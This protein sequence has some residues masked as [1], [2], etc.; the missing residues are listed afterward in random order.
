MRMQTCRRFREKEERGLSSMPSGSFGL[1][2]IEECG[3]S[4]CASQSQK[5]Q[6]EVICENEMRRGQQNSGES[7]SSQI[8]QRRFN[9]L[10]KW[11]R[12]ILH[13]RALEESAG[14]QHERHQADAISRCPEMQFD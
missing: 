14:E 4:R 3:N 11:E 5:H 10:A 9:A 6:P 2:W 1:N 7:A 8:R 12:R 13:I